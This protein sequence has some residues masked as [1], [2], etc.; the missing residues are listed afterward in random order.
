MTKLL[1]LNKKNFKRV[2]KKITLN[3]NQL[4]SKTE[5][6]VNK[7]INDV[8]KNGDR[9]LI[10][11]EKRFNNNS[12]IIPSN[13]KIKQSIDNLGP[14]IKKAI[15]DTYN[16]ITSWHKLQNKKDIYQR[17]KFGNRFQYINRPL[18]SAAV[19]CPG[20]LPSTALMNS[21]L[22]KIAGVK[23]LVL[24]TPATNGKL[25]GSVMYAARLCN[26]SQIINLSGASAI[27]ALSIGTK[28]IKPV[29]IVTGPGSRYVATA[30]RILSYKN[31][32]AQERM[33]AGESE[34]IS[35]C[36]NS[37]SPQ[38]IAY[39]LL[40]QSEHSDG[41][42]SIMIS[43]DLELIKK[44]KSKLKELINNLPRKKI[45]SKSLKKN[46]YFIH[47]KTD[48]EIL[49]CIEYISPEHLELQINKYK[50]YINKLHPKLSTTG[51]IA[52]GPFSSMALSDYGP[53]QH[54]LPTGGSARFAGGLNVGDFCKCISVNE[55]SKKGLKFL[56]KSGYILA[57]EE[58]LR[59]HSLSIK[60]KALRSK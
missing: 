23:R 58:K 8:T 21:S 28:K 44:V 34:I 9:A 54:S 18:K 10:K 46:G 20:N 2:L 57:E 45:I 7:I 27:A 42:L 24:S 22:A 5:I 53:T 16:R 51:S 60:T 6:I 26:L 13:N 12:I 14:E 31:L 3:R 4:D 1:I 37:A 33:Y 59:G 55:L 48:K 36:D 50:K 47:A 25:N 30:K 35:W 40:A 43:K 17:D 29:D 19:Y 15:R 56:S 49:D 11:Y 39:S 32:I 38:E 52:A 41:V